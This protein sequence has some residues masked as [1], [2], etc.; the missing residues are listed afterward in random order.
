MTDETIQAMLH[1]AALD[2]AEYAAVGALLAAAR[3]EAS[4]LSI[5][6]FDAVSGLA[7]ARTGRARR[8]AA[9][10][11]G[12]TFVLG[13][14]A[15]TAAAL[16]VVPEPARDFLDHIVTALT[17]DHRDSPGSVGDSSTPT[18]ATSA[19]PGTPASKAPQSVGGRL[20]G[21]I[22]TT[23]QPQV[24]SRPDNQ[25][26]DSTAAAPTAPSVAL[27]TPNAVATTPPA[28]DPDVPDLPVLPTPTG[29]APGERLVTGSQ[30]SGLLP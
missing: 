26:E 6:P 27:P 17:P 13:G 2:D 20:P 14:V 23:D 18:P 8:L 7:R 11:I 12:A 24:S 15:G 22:P 3:V 9:A 5:P 1:E 4:A 28:L 21:A 30:E 19:R 10:A 29:L 25:R 16:G